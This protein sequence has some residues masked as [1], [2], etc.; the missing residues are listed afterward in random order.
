MLYFASRQA[1]LAC[2][3]REKRLAK[4]YARVGVVPDGTWKTI[5]RSLA[6]L[7]CYPVAERIFAKKWKSNATSN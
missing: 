5:C 6:I 4:S 1:E 7:T 3:L 2:A